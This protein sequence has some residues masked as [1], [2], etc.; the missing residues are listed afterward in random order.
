[1]RPSRLARAPPIACAL[2]A[3]ALLAIGTLTMLDPFWAF[4]FW[5]CL[6]SFAAPHWI[7]DAR[8][9][10]RRRGWERCAQCHGE[11]PPRLAELLGFCVRCGVDAAR[12]AEKTL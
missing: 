7:A 2:L 3:F 12:H 10:R 4:A 11:G 6:F 9:H 1:M 8:R 5:W